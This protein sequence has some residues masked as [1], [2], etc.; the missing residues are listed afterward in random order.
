M[1]RIVKEIY[2]DT[3]TAESAVTKYAVLIGGTADGQAKLP[4]AAN[5]TPL[6]VA[7]NAAADTESVEVVMFGPAICIASGAITKGALVAIAGTTGKVASITV[8]QTTGSQR[9]VGRALETVTTDG[10][11]I[12]VFVGANNFVAV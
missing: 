9:C 1:P 4:G 8:G 2:S 10:D 11:H 5:V 3:Y 7:K 6:G 12:A